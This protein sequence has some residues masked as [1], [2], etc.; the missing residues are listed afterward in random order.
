MAAAAVLL[1]IP[2]ARRNW[3][4]RTLLV[5]LSYAATLILFVQANKLTTAAHAIFLQSTAPFYLLL[6]GP[7]LLREPAR[8]SDYALLAV[9]GL[10]MAL[11]VL[12]GQAPARTAPD[13]RQGN[14]LALASGITWAATLAGLRWLSRHDAG[15]RQSMATVAAGNLAACLF[16]LPAAVP[17][18]FS[19]ADLAVIV[20][21]GVF[22]I[23][24]AYVFLTRGLGGVP[25]L[26]G[27]LLLLAEPALNP[28]WALL[29]HQER[30]SAAAVAG[31]GLILTASL[32]HALLRRRG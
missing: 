4:R 31:A 3:N 32:G 1:L 9:A 14:V 11:F 10:G 21:L 12:G 13:P 18:A 24:M 29:V 26:E 5:A 23:G 8:R 16:C 28:L 19:P 20:Y 15:G 22:Q 17:V 7:L 6:A 2:S 25:A 30:P 27:S